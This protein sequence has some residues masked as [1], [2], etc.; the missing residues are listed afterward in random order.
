M[1]QMRRTPMM[2]RLLIARIIGA[3]LLAAFS[4][5][6]LQAQERISVPAP[7]QVQKRPSVFSVSTSGGF[8]RIVIVFPGEAKAEA[9]ITN[10]VLSI[11]AQE[12]HERRERVYRDD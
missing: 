9:E 11:E 8:A 7:V 3:A 5:G 10:G 4:I 1:T 2:V 6:A 12:R